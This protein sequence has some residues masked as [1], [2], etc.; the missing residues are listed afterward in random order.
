MTEHSPYSVYRVNQ[1][2][3]IRVIHLS[4]SELLREGVMI[5]FHLQNS[6]M[7]RVASDAPYSCEYVTAGAALPI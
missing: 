2:T 4:Y 3:A 6:P 7:D 1:L 5:Y